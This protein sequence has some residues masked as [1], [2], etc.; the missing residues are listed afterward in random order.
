MARAE[1][2]D[3]LSDLAHDLINIEVNTIRA[4]GITGRKMPSWPH[5]L[6]DIAAIYRRYLLTTAHVDL[7]PF[8][9]KSNDD[10][11][12]VE[13]SRFL[14]SAQTDGLEAKTDEVTFSRLR[15]AAAWALNNRNDANHPVNED[16]RE[17]LFRIRRNCDQIKGLLRTIKGNDRYKDF[18][19]RS[20]S[21][22]AQSY[23]TKG[24]VAPN[25]PTASLVQIRKIWDIGVDKVMLQT[26]IQLDGDVINRVTPDASDPQAPIWQAHEKMIGLGMTHWRT[27]FEILSR[28]VG[29]VFKVLLGR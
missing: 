16:E 13:S 26:V 5:A 2:Q 17:I 19:G 24:T 6:I 28:L 1:W 4:T 12:A 9:R 25:L 14:E 11:L 22:L 29:G 15:Y 18:V 21:E 3:S 7:Q 8:W 23:E 10:D 27:M 20:R